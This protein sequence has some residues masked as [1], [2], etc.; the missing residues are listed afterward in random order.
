V[1]A[2]SACHHLGVFRNLT[3]VVSSVL[4]LALAGCA[5]D[6]PD[7]AGAD[8]ASPEST[9][10]APATTTS[11]DTS[12][13]G[14][15]D[16]CELL[17]DAQI[18]ELAGEPL[19]GG[20]PHT[21]AGQ[22]PA[23]VWGTPEKHVQVGSV[24]AGVWARGLPTVVEQLKASGAVDAA[25]LQK[26]EDAADLIATGESIPPGRACDLFSRLVEMNGL[27]KG[28]T[29]TVNL[30]PDANDPQAITGQACQGGIY[31]TVLLVRPDLSG[32]EEENQRVEQALHQAMGHTQD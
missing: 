17:T 5:G 28:S 32:S 13:A 20:Q 29:V 22:L 21:I 16:Q 12:D 25:N 31:T 8:P 24:S 18:A 27:A 4:L 19:A 11:P 9:S 1:N 23:C 30:V 3:V 26:L 2:R 6:E 7:D 14:D 10:S 15:V